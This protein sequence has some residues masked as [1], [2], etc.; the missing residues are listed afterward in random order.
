MMRCTRRRSPGPMSSYSASRKMLCRTRIDR[1]PAPSVVRRRDGR[2]S[3][4]PAVGAMPLIVA[5][6]SSS[7]EVTLD[8]RRRGL[9]RRLPRCSRFGR[10]DAPPR[11]VD[12]TPA[13]AGRVDHV[14]IDFDAVG[15]EQ[16]SCCLGGEERVAETRVEDDIDQ[17]RIR[18]RT[19]RFGDQRPDVGPIEWIEIDRR[20]HDPPVRAARRG[21]RARRLARA[22]STGAWSRSSGPCC[23]RSAEARRISRA[24]E[25]LRLRGGPPTPSRR[26]RLRPVGSPDRTVH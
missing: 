18:H 1:R 2:S 6:S 19:D 12:A 25:S 9:W 20:G 15:T 13:E 10:S 23:P 11:S 7:R 3:R 26:F 5:T 14:F 16:R 4:S 8:R 22:G 21:V 24:T 17:L